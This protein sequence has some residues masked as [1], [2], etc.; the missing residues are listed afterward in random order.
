MARGEH[1]PSCA[2]QW[3][4]RAEREGWS[5]WQ[6]VQAI[7]SCCGVRLLKAH[8]LAYGWKVADAVR[9]FHALADDDPELEPVSLTENQLNHWENSEDRPRP[10]TIDRLCRLYRT[11]PDRLGFGNDYSESDDGGGAATVLVT[12]PSSVPAAALRLQLASGAEVQPN[13]QGRESARRDLDPEEDDVRLR[14]ILH[15]AGVGLSNRVLQIVESVRRRMDGTLAAATVDSN[16]LEGMEEAA[17]H[18]GY[19]FHTMPPLPLLCDVV[20]DF[21]EVQQHL[22][23]RQPTDFQIRLCRIT[24]ELAVLAGT[25]LVDLGDHREARNWFRTARTAADETG[26]RSLRAWVRAREAVVF[27]YHGRPPEIALEV[28]QH[29]EAIAGNTR[30]AASA[31]APALAARAFARMGRTEE[32]RRALY[33]AE[34]AFALLD[35]AETRNTIYGYPEKQLR[36]HEATTLTQIN[37]SRRAYQAQQRALSLYPPTEHVTPTLIRLDR[38]ACL[39]HDGDP[40]GGFRFAGQA[41][42]DV[43]EEYRTPLVMSRARELLAAVPTRDRGQRAVREYLD[44]LA[45]GTRPA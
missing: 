13:G 18:H 30:C 34:S 15:N 44:I 9:E 7:A 41:L 23:R 14:E 3:R 38:A 8:R 39:I 21:S 28:A 22:S 5:R 33:R 31:M 25:V 29:A 11:R 37:D 17:R 27:L 1:P 16:F 26:D 10:W 6:T 45:L 35:E 43:A 36:F 32:A 20:L 12:D 24:A 4:E 42:L 2:A 19:A 40:A